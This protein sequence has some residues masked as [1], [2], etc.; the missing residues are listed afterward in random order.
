[1]PTRRKPTRTRKPKGN[2]LVG[3]RA[4]QEVKDAVSAEADSE[5]RSPSNWLLNLVVTTLRAKGRLPK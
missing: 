2:P 4:P 3:F 5:N 1:M